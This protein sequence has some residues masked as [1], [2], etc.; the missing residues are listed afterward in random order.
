MRDNKYVVV[1]VLTN[2]VTRAWGPFSGANADRA[3]IALAS[4]HMVEAADVVLLESAGD[5]TEMWPD[6]RRA[7]MYSK[8]VSG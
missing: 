6:W 1:A 3:E 5:L 4:S 2:G 8:R 7:L